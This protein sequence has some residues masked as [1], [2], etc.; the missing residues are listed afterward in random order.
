M[1]LN[2]NHYRVLSVIGDLYDKGEEPPYTLIQL[3]LHAQELYPEDFGF[4]R[5][6]WY[7]VSSWWSLILQDLSHGGLVKLKRGDSKHI[8]ILVYP[9]EYSTK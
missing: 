9:S 6:D 7:R 2:P 1:K 4:P 8:G 5:P 3:D